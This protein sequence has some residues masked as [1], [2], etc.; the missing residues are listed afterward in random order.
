MPGDAGRPRR[1]NRPKPRARPVTQSA[2]PTPDANDPSDDW[3]A[4]TRAS[5]GVA[6]MAIATLIIPTIDL[7]AKLLGPGGGAP[8]ATLGAPLPPLEI[9]WARFLFQTLITAPLALVIVGRGVLWPRHLA[10]VVLRGALIG[11]A[12]VLFFTSLVFL[13]IA[14]AIA[15]FFVEPLILTVLSALVLGET[16]GWRRITAVLIGFIGAVL[17]IRPNFA[18]VGWPAALPLAT[19]ACFAV[20]LLLT[21]ILSEREHP[22]TLHLWAGLSGMA[23]LSA[24]LAAGAAIGWDAVAPRA[25]TLAQWGVLAALGLVATVG[26]FLVVMAFRRAPASQLAPLQYLEIVSAGLLGWLVFGE[27]MDTMSLIG[28]AIIIGSGLVVIRRERRRAI[29]PTLA[30]PPTV[31]PERPDA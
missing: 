13:G 27:V 31:E 7:F 1:P 26:H 10:L 16:I 25:P 11:V 6:L 20:Y 22:L 4:A 8:G 23:V 9:G 5:Q 12:T 15:V 2:T 19:A 18:Q 21:K 17:V 3:R 28:V 24:L 30:R 14:E 29:V